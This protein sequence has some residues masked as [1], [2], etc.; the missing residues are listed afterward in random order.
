MDPKMMTNQLWK[1][2]FMVCGS[3][4]GGLKGW[5]IDRTKLFN[6][7][8]GQWMKQENQTISARLWKK[9]CSISGMQIS[10]MI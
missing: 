8:L 9:F 10:R 5:Q 1:T 6:V 3:H 2:K 7:C 4:V